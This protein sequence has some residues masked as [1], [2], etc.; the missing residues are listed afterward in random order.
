MAGRDLLV[1]LRQDA[2]MALDR[3]RARMASL[4]T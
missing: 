2:E 4:E 1:E 3:A